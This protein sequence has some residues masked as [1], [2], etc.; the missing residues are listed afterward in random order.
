MA[1]NTIG[2]V[3][4]VLGAV[5]DVHFDGELPAILNAVKCENQGKSLIME[6]AQ[7]LGEN[8]VRCIAMD[9]TDGMVRGQEVTDTGEPISMPVGPETLGR[10]LNVIGDPIDE[11]GPIGHKKTLPIHRSAPEFTEQST[12]TEQLV[13]GIKVVDLL[14]PYAKLSN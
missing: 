3:S 2:S 6:V 14:T 7:H 5:V 4:Q 10:I 8:T 1:S 11:R 13:T 12:E 9:T